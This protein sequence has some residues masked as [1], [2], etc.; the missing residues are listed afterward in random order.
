M[1]FFEFWDLSV[2][3]RPQRGSISVAPLGCLACSICS[4]I[5]LWKMPLHNRKVLGALFAFLFS[6]IF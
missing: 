3:M 6:G 5:L 4:I 1:P 2:S